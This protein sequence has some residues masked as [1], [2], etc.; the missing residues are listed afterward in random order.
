MN[1]PDAPSNF[2][3]IARPLL[4]LSSSSSS[5]SRPAYAVAPI[6]PRAFCTQ[7]SLAPDFIAEEPYAVFAVLAVAAAT[8]NR[9][10]TAPIGKALSGPVCAMVCTFLCTAF[11]MI[12]PAG[13]AVTDAQGLAVRLATP[14]LL[15][16]ANLRDVGK[17]ASMMLPA[18]LVGTVASALGGLVASRILAGPL[19][20]AYGADGLK[21]AAALT[22]KN[23]GGGLNFVAVAAALQLSPAPFAAALAMDNIM[24]LVYFPLCA[25][26]G[27]N[28]PDPRVSAGEGS[29]PSIASGATSTAPPPATAAPSATAASSDRQSSAQS[30]ALAFALVAVAASRTLAARFAPGF[31][32]P[33]STILA[34]FAATAFPRVIAR[35]ASAGDELGTTTIYIFFATAG[36]VGG[37]LSSGAIFGGG[38]ALLGWLG[39][40]YAVHLSLLLGVAALARRLR[41]PSGGGGGA[42]AWTIPMALVASNANIGGPATASA[43]AVGNGWPS[44]VTPG[45]LVGNLGYALATPLGILLHGI[46]R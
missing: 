36:W 18:F 23:I 3:M 8:G 29:P 44:L 6:A 15:L 7:A 40:L 4:L 14:L 20:A 2:L 17:R 10:S 34:V 25:W 5:A 19:I 42:G 13:A 30:G 41:P 45:L 9:L 27:R 1:I 39:I 12:P 46:F 43:L 21:A 11:G 38:A 22:A 26:L 35:F 16:N 32:L 31:E 37:G 24:A 33:I 28:D